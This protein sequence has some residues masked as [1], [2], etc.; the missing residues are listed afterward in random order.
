MVKIAEDEAGCG[1]VL[2]IGEDRVFPA[3][4]EL[5]LAEISDVSPPGSE[6]SSFIVTDMLQDQRIVLVNPENQIAASDSYLCITKTEEDMC[7][8]MCPCGDCPEELPLIRSK[9]QFPPEWSHLL[10]SS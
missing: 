1:W 5:P 2:K 9:A 8:G 3:R 4:N 7:I 6:V 10:S